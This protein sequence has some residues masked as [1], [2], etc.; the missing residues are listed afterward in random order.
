M[1]F[2]QPNRKHERCIVINRERNARKKNLIASPRIIHQPR[3]IYIYLKYKFHEYQR[4]SFSGQIKT[5]RESSSM[6]TT[7]INDTRSCRGN[8]VEWGT[9]I[10]YE[11]VEG[12]SFIRSLLQVADRKSAL[13][14]GLGLNRI[15]DQNDGT[16]RIERVRL[17]SKN[18][19][20]TAQS[21]VSPY[22]R[23]N[24]LLE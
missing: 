8:K 10:F 7:P 1:L 18:L 5:P 23:Y 16:S 12:I 20:R 15:V 17:V 19:L 13:W 11:T 6:K 14:T 21:T 24:N 4:R 3:Y 22:T 9:V 2:V